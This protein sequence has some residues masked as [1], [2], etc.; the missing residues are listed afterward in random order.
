M[1]LYRDFE[2]AELDVQYNARGT[3]ADIMPILREYAEQSAAARAALPCVLDVSF[4]DHPDETLDIF[5]AAQP[6]APVFF[7]IHGGYWRLL[8]KSDSSFM[9]PAMT[10]AGATVVSINYSLAPAVTLD[11]IVDQTRRALAWVYRHIARHHG[12]ARRIH[13]CGSSAGG[14]LVGMLLAGG[15]H[16]AYG[17]PEDVVQSAAPLSGLFELEPLVH[18]HIN[19]WM[20]LSPADALRNSPM[21]HLPGL[22]CPLLVSYGETETAEFKRQS[23]D[24]L[25]AWRQRGFAGDYLAMPGTNHYDIILQLNNPAS[26][27]TRA[28][29]RL[30]GLHEK[31]N[32]HLETA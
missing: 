11:R 29:F 1:P 17:V 9:A 2:Q 32:G 28:I 24:Y 5:P 4:G 14:H 15:W 22:G 21:A 13:V 20:H 6:D 25:Q 23:D 7:F 16:A 31:D 26:V 27:L 10:A 30:M 18:T 3:V 19:E 8:S 12:D